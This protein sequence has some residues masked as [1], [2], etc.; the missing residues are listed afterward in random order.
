VWQDAWA[1]GLEYRGM[2]C[3]VKCNSLREV[4]KGLIHAPSFYG[5]ILVS[6]I[7]NLLWPVRLMRGTWYFLGVFL[8]SLWYSI[9][10]MEYGK[11]CVGFEVFTAVTMTSAVL[12]DVAPHRSCVNRRFGGTYR[13]HLQ[14]RKI[15][16]RG[17]SMRGGCQTELPVENTQLYKNRGK[18][19][20]WATWEIN[21]GEG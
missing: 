18:G 2:C 14:G 5:L 6:Q 1:T 13:L 21:R 15:R 20:E 8:S 7:C 19:G 9:Q 11:Y 3:R 12:W 10:F 17:T 4:C 16:E